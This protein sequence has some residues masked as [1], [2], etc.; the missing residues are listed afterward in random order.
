MDLKQTVDNWF[1]TL[2][3][4]V[5]MISNPGFHFDAVYQHC[6][7]ETA[8]VLMP[9]GDIPRKISLQVKK[10]FLASKVLQDALSVGS[11][12]VDELLNMRS[13]V[14]CAEAFMKMTKCPMCSGI[15]E[16]VKPCY[17][18]CMNVM[19]GCTAY[20]AVVG[21]AWNAYVTAL[22]KLA[23]KADGPFSMEAIIDPLGVKIS[24]GIMFFQFNRQNITTHVMKKCGNPPPSEL[25]SLT[26]RDLSDGM[27][28]PYKFDSGNDALRP[29]TAYGTSLYRLITNLKKVLALFKDHWVSLPGNACSSGFAAPDNDMG[30]CWNGEAV[31]SYK[32]PVVKDGVDGMFKNP[33]VSLDKKDPHLTV[34][35]QVIKLKEITQRILSA[36][37]G[38]DSNQIDLEE[39]SG[40]GSGYGSGSGSGGG[41][42]SGVKPTGWTRTQPATY[43][44]VINTIEDKKTPPSSPTP[45]MGNTIDENDKK[46]DENNSENSADISKSV[47]GKYPGSTSSLVTGRHSFSVLCSIV[48]FFTFYLLFQ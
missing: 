23:I 33:E 21:P 43:T 12:V 2:Y 19:K 34:T 27:A 45:T 25:K 24:E 32:K 15:A 17:K 28:Y 7:L 42:G 3:Q 26:K 31:D 46:P 41:D 44:D 40:D 29:T 10:S 5:Y 11:R 48:G 38:A 14:K 9:F 39:S 6:L 16:K 4:K 37:N 20:P 8:D 35:R 30:K 1:S 47:G 36:V 18:Y 22:H 13:N